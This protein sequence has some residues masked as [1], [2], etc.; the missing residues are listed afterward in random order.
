MRFTS[1]EILMLRD[2][3]LLLCHTLSSIR[4]KPSKC[5]V[6]CKWGG[7]PVVTIMYLS[8]K[9][10]KV[11]GFSTGFFSFGFWGTGLLV[12]F[13]SDLQLANLSFSI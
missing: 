13:S 7:S 3:P 9:K 1:Y 4:E 8:K 6:C 10:K 2:R 12:P 11:F 5:S